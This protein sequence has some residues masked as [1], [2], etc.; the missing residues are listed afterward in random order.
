MNQSGGMELSDKYNFIKSLRDSED[1]E[2]RKYSRLYH[3]FLRSEN[4]PPSCNC[5]NELKFHI[6]KNATE[7]VR[8]GCKLSEY[9]LQIFEQKNLFVNSDWKSFLNES[10]NSLDGKNAIFYSLAGCCY[11]E[12]LGLFLFLFFLFLFLFISL[13]FFIFILSSFPFN[14]FS[15]LL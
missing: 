11:L 15:L 2:M 4:I 6:F 7:R 12:G 14:L 13:S 10:K 5:M 9:F 1:E 8:K 3:I